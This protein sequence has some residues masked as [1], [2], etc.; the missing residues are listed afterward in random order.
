MDTEEICTWCGDAVEMTDRYRA[1][2]PAGERRATFCRLEHIVP[3]MIQGPRW[4]PGPVDEPGEIAELSPQAVCSQCAG[5]LRDSRALLVRHRGEHRVI[6]WFC[7]AD[8]M[9]VWARSGGR[10]Q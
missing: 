7:S 6:D 1:Y 5:P 3:W 2:E 8:H 10:W 9:A 4:E